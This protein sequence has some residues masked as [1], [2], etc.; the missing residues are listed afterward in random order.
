[1]S[2]LLTALL[3]AV[4]CLCMTACASSNQDTY[5]YA[6]SAH[7]DVVAGESVNFSNFA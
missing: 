3:A 1:M 7:R 5:E 6:E 2:K 4:C